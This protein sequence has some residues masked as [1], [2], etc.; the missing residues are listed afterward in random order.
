M[1]AN[2]AVQFPNAVAVQVDINEGLKGVRHE[3]VPSDQKGGGVGG[4]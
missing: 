2:R 4:V 1:E 3:V